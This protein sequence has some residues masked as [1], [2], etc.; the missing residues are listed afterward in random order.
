[1]VYTGKTIAKKQR[2]KENQ[3]TKQK[4]WSE[5]DNEGMMKRGYVIDKELSGKDYTVY[6]NPKTK[7]ASIRYRETD[8]SNWRD[9]TTDALV[10]T[11][12]QGIGSRFK[13]AEKVYDRAAQKYGGKGNVSVYGH[14]LGGTQALHV[15]QTRGASAWAYNPGVG[16]IEPFKFVYNETAAYLGDKKAKRRV[17]NQKQKAQVYHNRLDPI[18]ALAPISGNYKNITTKSNLYLNPH[19]QSSLKRR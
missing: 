10:F 6:Y 1:M 17:K 16:P 14:S 19:S 13:R 2:E 12:L 18:S 9:L 3:R 15:N 5:V 8:P 7:K 11:G 4:K